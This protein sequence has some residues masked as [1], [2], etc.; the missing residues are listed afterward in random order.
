MK[1]LL[2]IL[3][4]IFACDH[5]ANGYRILGIFPVNSKSHWAM[6][7][8]LMV[9]LARRGHQVD[10]VTYFPLEQSEPNYK[11]INLKGSM[12]SMIN[13]LS[14]SDMH[15]FDDLNMAAWTNF[16][17]SNVCE[18]M[19]E[20][21]LHDLIENPPE[22]PPYDLVITEIF[23]SPCYLAFGRHL[24]VPVIGTV[25][26]AFHDWL[27][28]VTGNPECSSYV[29]SMLSTFSQQMTFK[30]RLLN[31]LIRNYVS[32]QLHY[33][34]NPQVELVK[35]HFGI[36]VPHIKDL[37][38]DVALYLVNSHHT[39]NGIRPM[40]NNVIE[41]GGL[42]LKDSDSPLSPEVQKWLDESKDGCV[43]FTFGSMVRIETFPEEKLKQFYA[44]FDKIAPVRVLMKVAKKE[45][46]LPGLP[47][48]VMTQSWFPQKTVLKHKNIRA[49]ITHGGLMGTQEAI[50]F[51]I[52][53]IGISL[54]GDQ[55]INIRN[56][57]N[58]KV[59]ISPG[60]INHITEAKLTSAL[61]AIL[62]DPT[63]RS[64]VQKLSKMFVDR[65]TSPLNTAIF[66]VEYIAKYGSVLQSPAI[67][68]YWWQRELL[69]IFAFILLVTITVFFIVSF[70]F[71]KL[72]KLLFG[73]RAKDSV[74]IK[75]KKNK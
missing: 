60:D 72:P 71:R 52:P 53:L 54:F 16:A 10:V 5:I 55:H 34:T 37:Y 24:K 19:N 68:L 41:V 25:T 33:Y 39:L 6:Q 8:S 45:D 56:Y 74:E 66:W 36:D 47:K 30:E 44:S 11:E 59:A 32:I 48:N 35:K 70:I 67:R 20:P 29:P 12:D 31:F 38:N 7:E 15:R 2:S 40:T 57:V 27:N 61:N 26:C 64:N 69:D 22:D 3:F 49:F 51:G 23:A 65:P 63:Y 4:V 42:H 28:E 75:S 14:A 62:K 13:N 17:G 46:L 1:D 73:S 21:K 50:Y 43:Y 18:L 58:K 9:G